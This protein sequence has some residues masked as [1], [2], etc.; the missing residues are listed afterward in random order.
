MGAPET[1]AQFGL[2]GLVIFALFWL[3]HILITE[4]KTS[5]MEAAASFERVSKLN[6]ERQKETNAVINALS[7]VIERNTRGLR[8]P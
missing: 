4:I 1:W 5:R 7:L 2:A 6:D 3:V 8:Q